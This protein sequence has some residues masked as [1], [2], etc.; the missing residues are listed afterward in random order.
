MSLIHKYRPATFDG[1][2]GNADTVKKIKNLLDKEDPKRTFLLS[3]PRGT[4]KTTIGRIIAKH[5]GCN[6]DFDF[7][8]VDAAALNGVGPARDLRE[9]C[10]YKSL[11]TG[12]RVWLVDEC[13]RMTDAAQEILL[14]TFEEPPDH[15][16]FVLATTDPQ[17][18]KPT[19]IDRFAHFKMQ[20][21]SEDEFKAFIKKIA[22]RE[23]TTLPDEVI[24]ALYDKAE[25]RPRTGLNI[26]EKIIG[27]PEDEMIALV[28][29]EN[30]AESEV[31]ELCRA[32]LKNEGWT[33]LRKILNSIMAKEDPETIRRIVMGYMASVLL[34]S[35]NIKAF[36]IM[37][38]FKS[39]FYENGKNDLVYACYNT[40]RPANSQ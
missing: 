28:K 16:F 33:S 37:D 35:D 18:L 26:L 14:K 20:P 23:K 7:V 39:P 31:L 2:V 34:K 4:G 22:R 3:G 17:K 5:I 30:E 8:E 32:L 6:L 36:E 13:H 19:V 10:L 24:D 29:A 25:G 12:P 1:V 40:F 9:Q 15:V 27:T 38:N 11:T 21:L